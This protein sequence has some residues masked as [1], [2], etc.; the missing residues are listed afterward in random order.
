[1]PCLQRLGVV[2]IGVGDGLH[3]QIEGLNRPLQE[4]EQH[5]V[6]VLV[7]ASGLVAVHTDEGES[8]A[9]D[10]D[11]VDLRVDEDVVDVKRNSIDCERR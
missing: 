5:V 6:H 2:G 8:N 7:L 9:L 4:V 3:H 10:E 11:V 1:M